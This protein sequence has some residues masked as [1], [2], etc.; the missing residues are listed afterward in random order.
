[1]VHHFI[2][3]LQVGYL[4]QNNILSKEVAKRKKNCMYWSS[5]C[6]QLLWWLFFSRPEP[7]N[8]QVDGDEMRL[9]TAIERPICRGCGIFDFRLHNAQCMPNA[10]AAKGETQANRIVIEHQYFSSNIQITR[11]FNL[12]VMRQTWFV[13]SILWADKYRTHAYRIQIT[14]TYVIFL[15][16]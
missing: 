3:L 13:L 2:Y 4:C 15:S 14:R 6:N 12:S 10:L 9:P 7:V 11:K 8:T 5:N 16:F 1:M